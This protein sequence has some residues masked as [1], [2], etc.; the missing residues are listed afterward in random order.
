MQI[1]AQN[2]D[3]FHLSHLYPS[4]FHSI[5]SLAYCRM[6]CRCCICFI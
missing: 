1:T 5:M 3:C 6:K 2:L 4:E